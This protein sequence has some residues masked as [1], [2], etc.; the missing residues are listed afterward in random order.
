MDIYVHHVAKTT[1]TFVT[2]CV[3]KKSKLADCPWFCI[4]PVDMNVLSTLLKHELGG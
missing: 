3:Q 1:A 4:G 2:Q